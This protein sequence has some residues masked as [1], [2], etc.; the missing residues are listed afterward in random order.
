MNHFYKTE[1]GLHTLQHRNITLNAK[2][3][4]LL[5][6]IGSDDF[7]AMRHDQKQR[8]ANIEL[9]QQLLDLGLIAQ[10]QNTAIKAVSE[11]KNT[12]LA[13]ETHRDQRPASVSIE[14]KELQNTAAADHLKTAPANELPDSYSALDIESLQQLMIQHLQQYCGLMAKSLIEKIS[15]SSC[16]AELKSCQMQWITHLQ[17]SRISHMQLNQTLQHIN[18]SLNHMQHRQYA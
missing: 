8:L 4:R 13:P 12:P 10:M 5:I 15:Q 1:L 9:L 14:F 18:F 3:R 16:A 17:E 7:N 2:Q 11:H 6:L